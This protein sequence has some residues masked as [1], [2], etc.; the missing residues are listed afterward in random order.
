VTG[1]PDETARLLIDP[2]EHLEFVAV[3]RQALL[4]DEPHRLPHQILVVSSD[5]HVGASP[6]QG[7][8]DPDVV[9]VDDP[10]V[11]VGDRPWLDVDTLAEPGFPGWPVVAFGRPILTKSAAPRFADASRCV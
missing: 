5:L 9:L 8:E 6:D 11:P 4:L 3:A 10:A 2:Q 7:L 1:P